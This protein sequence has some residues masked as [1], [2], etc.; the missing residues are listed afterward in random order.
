MAEIAFSTL[1]P[2]IRAAGPVVPS[3]TV[4]R[5]IRR[6]FIE[7]CRRSNCYRADIDDVTVAA[8]TADIDLSATLPANTVLTRPIKLTVAERKFAASSSAQVAECD[9]AWHDREGTY[10][11]V[12]WPSAAAVGS[13]RIYPM[14]AVALSGAGKGISGEVAVQPSRTAT[15]IEEVMLER[16]FDAAIDN[17]LARLLMIAD[18]D[19]YNPQQAAVHRQLFEDAVLVAKADAENESAP[20]KLRT[21]GY[22]GI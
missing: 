19:W 12:W 20:D 5:E 18:A 10:P 1:E 17:V 3:P 7:L 4:V 14:A 21:T 16:Y 6:G 2:E 9:P 8:S 11:E 13:I 15:G 22:G